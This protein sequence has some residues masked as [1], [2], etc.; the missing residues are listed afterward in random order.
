M[1]R[2]LDFL[3][4]A[5][6]LLVL[7]PL[8]AV[9]AIAVRVTSPGPVLF[10]QRRMGLHMKPFYILK[11]RTM[12]EN[13]AELGPGITVGEDQRITKMGH[14]LRKTKIDELPQL[15]NVLCGDM[16]LVGSRPELEQYVLMYAQDYRTILK[17]RPGITDVASIVYRDESEILAQSK[18]PEETYVHVVLPEVP[19]RTGPMGHICLLRSNA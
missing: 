10:K 1:K 8:F 17:A 9:V 11:F 18:D 6:G 16:A 4:S 5:V 7:A 15:W 12:V 2:V 14:L 19:V 3:L 13:A